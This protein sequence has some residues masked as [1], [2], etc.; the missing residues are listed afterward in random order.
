MRTKRVDLRK[1]SGEQNPA[2]L[3]TKHSISRQRLEG[4]V[5]LFGCRYLD[6]RAA[7]APQ[8]RTGESMRVTMADADREIGA[9]SISAVADRRKGRRPR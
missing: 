2:D 3:L 6:G 5:A 1:V 4:L 8:T 7:S 9:S